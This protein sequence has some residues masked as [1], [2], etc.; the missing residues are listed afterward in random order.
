MSVLV[1]AEL[2]SG[3][4][5]RHASPGAARRGQA[6]AGRTTRPCRH[7]G[8]ALAEGL[9]GLL[10]LAALFWAVPWVGRYHDIALVTAQASHHAAMHRTRAPT[11]DESAHAPLPAMLAGSHAGAAARWRGPD[12]RALVTG[13]ALG[14]ERH[15]AGVG[16]EPGQAH[17]AAGRLRE[18]WGAVSGLHLARVE[19]SVR[20]PLPS[21][22]ELSVRRASVVM[23]DAGH[24]RSDVEAQQRIAAG[25]H[26]W[27]RA[28]QASYAAGARVA[29]PVATADSAW[30][31][32][33]PVLDW[34]SPWTGLAPAAR[35]REARP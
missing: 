20:A 26:G 17:G 7:A 11:D 30:P 10:A 34:L 6:P 14:R 2:G 29:G 24:A 32:E 31:R 28:A 21:M 1:H 16:T 9:V 18:D 5:T 27:L 23:A 25:R 4:A 22:G 35:V 33:A 13:V 15:A 8:Q 19:T 3:P 12:G